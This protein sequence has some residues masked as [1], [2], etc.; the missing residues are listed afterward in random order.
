MVF[1]DIMISNNNY[2]ALNPII[3]AFRGTGEKHFIFQQSKST[4]LM[5]TVCSKE[6]FPVILSVMEMI[7][8]RH[9]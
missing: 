1:S 3:L 7:I 6:L 4:A 9:K 2:K 5:V 8:S